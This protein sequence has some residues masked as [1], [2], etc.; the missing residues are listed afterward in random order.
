ML[1]LPAMEAQE[2]PWIETLVWTK[3][4]QKTTDTNTEDAQGFNTTE[5]VHFEDLEYNNPEKLTALPRE[6]DD[7]HQ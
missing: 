6:I 2:A 5:K 7:L 4:I 3:E 1:W